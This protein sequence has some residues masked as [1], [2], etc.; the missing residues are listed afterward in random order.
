[1]NIINKK[2]GMF[3]IDET[4]LKPSARTVNIKNALYLAV[5]TEFFGAS[6]NPKYKKL[7]ISNR[8]KALNDFAEKWLQDRGLLNE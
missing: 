8:F 7:T 2:R 1:M 4:T 6:E 5:N 3:V